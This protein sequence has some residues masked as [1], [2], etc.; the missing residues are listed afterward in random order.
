[1]T[2]QET[3]VKFLGQ[4]DPLEKEMATHSRILAQEIPQTEKPG[5]LQSTGSTSLHDYRSAVLLSHVPLKLRRS[6]FELSVGVSPGMSDCVHRECQKRSSWQ[7]NLE[8][9]FEYL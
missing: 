4:E 2:T 6:V 8:V 5:G 7:L 1:M 3:Q 9:V